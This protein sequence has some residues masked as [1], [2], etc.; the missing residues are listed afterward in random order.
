MTKKYNSPKFTIVNI[1]KRDIITGSD[2]YGKLE[3]GYTTEQGAAGRRF[4]DWYEGY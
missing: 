4:D 3:G 2:P 1:N